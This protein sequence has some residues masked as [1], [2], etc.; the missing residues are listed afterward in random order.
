MLVTK[1]RGRDEK[2]KRKWLVVAAT[3]YVVL[4]GKEINT[5]REVVGER[6]IKV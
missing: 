6:M 5:A 3:R 1:K 4:D 2:Q